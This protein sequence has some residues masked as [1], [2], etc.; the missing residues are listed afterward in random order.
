MEQ[1]SLVID[2]VNCIDL[3]SIRQTMV[4]EDEKHFHFYKNCLEHL[5]FT[6]IGWF[7]GRSLYAA[8]TCKN[9]VAALTEIHELASYLE[10]NINRCS[11]YDQYVEVMGLIYTL[12]PFCS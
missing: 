1:T 9:G 8:V 3:G 12:E 10:E 2:L 11:T 5:G 6:T 7:S 4:I